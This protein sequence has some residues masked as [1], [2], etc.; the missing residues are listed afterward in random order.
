MS[1]SPPSRRTDSTYDALRLGA[2]PQSKWL[3]T[4]LLIGKTYDLW[5]HPDGSTYITPTGTLT[6]D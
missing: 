4:L 2:G 6:V 5:Q 3:R 1:T